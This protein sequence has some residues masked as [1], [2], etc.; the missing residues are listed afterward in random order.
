MNSKMSPIPIMSKLYMWFFFF[1]SN[2]KQI[3]MLLLCMHLIDSALSTS[4][5]SYSVSF[6]M[7]Y[8]LNANLEEE[9]RKLMEQL[10]QL[11]AQ[12]SEL[13]VNTLE[14]K[15]YHHEEARQLE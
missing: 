1:K 8:Q 2:N 13:L 3:K 9:N 4:H 5:W 6:Q 15:E 14:T 10:S 11:M 12:N 7:L